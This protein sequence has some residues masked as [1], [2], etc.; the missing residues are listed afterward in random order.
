MT[1]NLTQYEF[2]GEKWIGEKASADFVA[3]FASAPDS[4]FRKDS[5]LV[6]ERKLRAIAVAPVDGQRQAHIKKYK[7]AGVVPRL[8]ALLKVSQADL[9]LKYLL[10]AKD[11]GLPA[12]DVIFFGR[13]GPDAYLATLLIPSAESLMEVIRKRPEVLDAAL[14]EALARLVASAHDA[15]F[16]HRDLHLGN[17]LRGGDGGLYLID[18]H[19]MEVKTAVSDEE[20]AENLGLL[21]FSLSRITGPENRDALMKAYHEIRRP[22]MGLEDFRALVS[23]ASRAWGRRHFRSRTRRCL[24]DGENFAVEKTGECIVHRKS[25][26]AGDIKALIAAHGGKSATILKE[27]KNT[28][29]TVLPDISGDSKICVKEYR[30]GGFGS[31]LESL[32]RGS[33]AKRAWTNANGLK[34]RGLATPEPLAYAR[35]WDAE[36]FVTRF[37]ANAQPLDSYLHER[38]E[39][40]ADRP[41]LR[42]KWRVMRDIGRWLARVHKAEVYH[43]DLKANNVL[44]AEE[45]GATRF[46]LL[47]LDR[48]RFDRPLSQAEIEFNMACLNAAVPNFISATDRMRVFKAY[49]GRDNISVSDKDVLRR[50]RDIS[51]ARDH[52]WHIAQSRLT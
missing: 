47:D 10:A 52:F 40:V 1:P 37:V 7:A 8:R 32:A 38:F 17:I 28:R 29:L 16:L 25:D 27:G 45:N 49:T 15:G 22:K 3:R 19:R 50:V 34:I 4:Y 36:Y 23:A 26:W 41:V 51:I 48:V 13:R 31:L 12:P 21:D 11:A 46:L 6:R 44:V 18:M 39:N 24:R 35:T 5:F 2:A 33:R 43:K 42:G 9:E 30:K 20:A 14:I